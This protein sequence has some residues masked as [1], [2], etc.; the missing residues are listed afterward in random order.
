MYE[1]TP[2]SFQEAVITK[3]LKTLVDI[4]KR[5]KDIRDLF[6]SSNE[7]LY[8]A[9]NSADK[10]KSDKYFSKLVSYLTAIC[11]D[12]SKEFNIKACLSVVISS[13]Q[14]MVTFYEVTDASKIDPTDFKQIINITKDGRIRLADQRLIISKIQMTSAILLNP[15]L[16]PKQLTAILLHEVGHIF[17]IPMIKVSYYLYLL[18]DDK[19]KIHSMNDAIKIKQKK[20][21]DGVFGTLMEKFT[22]ARSTMKANSSHIDSNDDVNERFADSFAAHYGYSAELAEALW[23][24]SY[25][26]REVPNNKKH[27]RI[28]SIL[29][30]IDQA[31]YDF[32]FR[33]GTYPNLFD[34]LLYLNNEM[35][36]ELEYDPKLSVKTKKMFKKKIDALNSKLEKTYHID[37]NPNG[38]LY[39]SYIHNKR[40]EKLKNMHVDKPDLMVLYHTMGK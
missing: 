25:K 37:E 1:Y 20:I 30:D 32:V 33:P 10:K 13:T 5:F 34:R 28:M 27:N 18:D 31:L 16:T 22:N 39:S 19:N 14:N 6:K 7:Y 35:K 4:E 2:A 8:E 26:D 23:T 12:L 9:L 24:I 36:Y 17:S 38:G 11:N 15:K 29:V 3:K 21:E 40:K